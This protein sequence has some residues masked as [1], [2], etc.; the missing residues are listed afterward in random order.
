[1]DHSFFW[2]GALGVNS[3]LIFFFITVLQRIKRRDFSKEEKLRQ[4]MITRVR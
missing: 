1:M 4:V 2:V 3:L